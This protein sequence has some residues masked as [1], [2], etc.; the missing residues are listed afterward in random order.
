MYATAR[1]AGTYLSQFREHVR[2]RYGIA[3]ATK[4][5]MDFLQLF[6]MKLMGKTER[7][8]G[9]GDHKYEYTPQYESAGFSNRSNVKHNTSN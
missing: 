7:Q 6:R 8:S 9:K 5:N 2:S 3:L 4:W 1:P